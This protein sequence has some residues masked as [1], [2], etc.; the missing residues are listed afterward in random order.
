MIILLLIFT[1]LLLASFEVIL[2]GG[3]LGVFAFVCTLVATWIGFDRYGFAAAL[4]IFLGTFFLVA[5]AL[6][7]ELK[8]LSKTAY[9]KR[10]FLDV[11][12]KGRARSNQADDSIIGE[13]GLTLTRLNPSGKISINGK[14]YEAHSQDGFIEVGQEIAVVSQ[15]NFKLTIKKL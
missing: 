13:K 3:V 7:L 6:V 9:G 4:V 2:P 1:T 8:L 5:L 15:D 12:V 10:F 14:H 11:A